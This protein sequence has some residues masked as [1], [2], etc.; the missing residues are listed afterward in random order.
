MAQAEQISAAKRFSEY[1]QGKGDEKQETARFWIELLQTVLG[2]ENPAQFIEFEKRVKLTHTSFIDGYIPSTKVLIEQK[3]SKIDLHKAYEQSDGSVLTPFQQAK[4]YADEMPNSI[5]PDWIV[6]CNFTE[7]LVYN[8]EKPHEEPVQILLKNLAKDYYLLNFLVQHKTDALQ[9][10][11]E[12]SIEAGKIVGELYDELLKQYKKKDDFELKS[13]NMLCVRLVFCLYAE[14]SGI[15]G[16]RLMFHD[17]LQSFNAENVRTALIDLFRVLD[18]PSEEERDHLHLPAGTEIRDPYLDEKFAQFPYVNGG[19]FKDEKILIPPFNDRIRDFLLNKASSFDWSEISPT[20]FGA[21]FE[22]TLNPETRRSGGMHY[23]SIENIHKVI[24][25]LF[26]DSLTQ[27]FEEIAAVKNAKNRAEKLLAFQKKLGSLTF[28]DPACGSGNFLTETYLSLRRL[29]N[30]VISLLNK[31]ERVFGFDEFI[32]V[33]ISQFYG[34]EINDFAVTVAKTALWIAESQMISETEQIIS[35]T[36]DFLPLTTNAFIVEGNALRMDW[37]TLQPL[38]DGHSERSEESLPLFAAFTTQVDGTAHHYD[39]IMGNP[40]FVG[41]SYQSREQKADMAEVFKGVK[42]YGN[43]DFVASWYKKATD[44]IAGTKTKCAFVSTN[45]I[46]QGIAVP[47]LWNYLFSKGIEI[48]FAYRTFKWNSESYDKAAVHCVII[49]FSERSEESAH[50][51]LNGR[52]ESTDVSHTLNMTGKRN[53][54]DIRPQNDKKASLPQNG[55]RIYNADGTVEEVRNINAYLIDAPNI[56]VEDRHKPF[57]DIPEMIVG[58][59]PTDGGGFILTAEEKD[60]FLKKEPDSEPYIHPYIGSD[61]F[62]N[63]KM[64]YCLWLKDVPPSK[65]LKMPLV[66]QRVE[67]V[68]A[69]R[70]ASKKEQTRKRAD[71]STLFAEDRYV[72]AKSIFV[73]MVSSENREYIPIGFISENVIANNKSLVVP[74][75]GLYIFGILT[76]SVHMAWMRTVAGRLESRYSYG[77]TTVY[78]TFP[79]C[80]PNDEQK[81][82]IEQTAQTILDARAKFPDCTLAQLYGENSYLFPE[83]VKAHQANDRAVTEAYGFAE[84]RGHDPLSEAEIVARLFAMY[85]ELCKNAGK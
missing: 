72:E 22:S 35:Q 30:R 66:K 44:F 43:L 85:E 49:G 9:R 7:F 16:K 6:V 61:E 63:G 84:T 17:F 28:L 50:V 13:L 3:G 46:C 41:K 32:Q 70:L 74:N 37:S 11:L 60:E 18:T 45:S 25:P 65:I 64:R 78:N 82:K 4:R 56:I 29:E 81:L 53:P 68:R 24:D 79:W 36:I 62:I 77:A 59:C 34:I 38:D 71:S 69:F 80:N 54:S 48:D 26:M 58:S 67:K 21:V 55:K 31:G 42:N 15:F 8:M 57:I 27:E 76:S 73:P 1:W 40:P 10:E 5:R 20:I 47:P 23:T 52:E 83:L 39:Y 12:L 2:V 33:K 14:D 19:L 51:I 75:G